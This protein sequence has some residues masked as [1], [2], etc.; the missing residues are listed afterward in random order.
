MPEIVMVAAETMPQARDSLKGEIEVKAGRDKRRVPSS[1][2]L[3][4]H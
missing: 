3:E 4:V 1:Y 2:S